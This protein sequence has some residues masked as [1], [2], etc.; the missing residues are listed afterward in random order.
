[1]AQSGGNISGVAVASATVGAVLI[2][3]ALRNVSP[4]QALKDI[5]SGD[6]PQVV[7]TAGTRTGGATAAGTTGGGS[8]QGS[9]I[10]SAA[11]KYIGTPYRWGG[12]SPGGFDCSGLVTYVL[13]HDLGL[14]LPNNQHTVTGTFLVW[15]GAV[16]VPASQKQPGDLVCWAGH[17]AIYS[18]NNR[19]IEAPHAG[20]KVRE[21]TLRSAGATFRR[22]GATPTEPRAG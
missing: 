13:H 14:T 17:I 10:V 2:Y 7:S 15:R 6:L 3:A 16:T 9:Q 1:V 22:V 8:A 20:A 12:A 18:G 5:L 11:R 19:M 4:A 21:T